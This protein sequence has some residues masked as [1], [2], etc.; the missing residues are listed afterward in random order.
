VIHW[1]RGGLIKKSK[2]RLMKVV[3]LGG[4]PKGTT[5][6]TMQYVNYI[7]KVLPSHDYEVIQISS[8]IKKL[9]R[10]EH[11]FSEV[12]EH[13]RSS[14][15]V[16]WAFPLYVLFV[17]SQYKRFIELIWERGVQ[18]AFANKYTA[19]LSTSIH[20]FDHTAHSYMHSICD[21]LE[22]NFAGFYSAEMHDLRE[23]EGQIKTRQFGEQIIESAMREVSIPKQFPALV[24]VE[25]EY[26]PSPVEKKV[27]F[28]GKRIVILHD[29]REGQN[30]LLNMIERIRGSFGGGVEVYN[31]HDVDMVAGCQGCMKCGQNYECAL[32][33]KD[34]YVDFYN[35]RIKPADILIFAGVINDRFLSSRWRMF[36]DRSFF[37][38][39]T[40]SLMG[41]QFGFVLSGP[42][43]QT[44]NIR[45]VFEGYVQWQR[46]NIVDFVSDEVGDSAELD[47]QLSGLAER[48]V[49][50]SLKGYIKPVTFL[51]TGA[52]KIF[53]DDIFSKLRFVFQADHRFY[54]KHGYYDFPQKKVGLRLINIILGLL[55]RVPRIRKRF[56][57]E[58]RKKMIEPHQRVVEAAQP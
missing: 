56:D 40:P 11:A 6:V 36:F 9:E 38:C 2:E 29:A 21:D 58:I 54:S 48:L 24:P 31:L 44:G 47:T 13:V 5:S 26:R 55:F 28:N 18:D 34:G 1:K 52:Y 15:L 51:G 17:P 53:R 30:N 49:W 35:G 16:I 43:S 7:R 10:D 19:V 57:Q 32:K 3:V 41:K 33:D 23:A 27:E 22:M 37:N 8:R 46:S 20:F 25:F 50:S 39:H 42:L 4:S 12:I 14:T 45:E